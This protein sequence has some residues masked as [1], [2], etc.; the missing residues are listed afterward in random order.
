MDTALEAAGHIAENAPLAVR[1]TRAGVRELLHLS[2]KEA[3]QRQEELGKPLRKTEDAREGARAF[4]ERRKP[5]W[6]GR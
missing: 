6:Q 5:I 2:L 1:A 4:L 3:Y